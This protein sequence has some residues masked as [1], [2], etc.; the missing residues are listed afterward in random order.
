MQE[1]WGSISLPTTDTKSQGWN[2]RKTRSQLSQEGSKVPLEVVLEMRG[3]W[4]LEQGRTFQAIGGAA[5]E[6]WGWGIV[7]DGGWRTLWLEISS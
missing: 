3:M 4:L 6:A 5:A 2:L 7:G 1:V